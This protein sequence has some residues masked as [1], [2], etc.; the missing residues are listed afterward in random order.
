M[1]GKPIGQWQ[2]ICLCLAL[3]ILGSACSL[4]EEVIRRGEVRDAMGQGQLLLGRGDF[5]GS[6]KAFTNVLTYAN[7]EPPADAAHYHL[8]LIHAHPQNSRQDRR[9]A[10]DSFD[11]VVSQFPESSFVQPAKAWI[12][13]LNEIDAKQQEIARTKA[14]ARKSKQEIEASRAAAERAKQD[15]DRVRAEL[16]KSRQEFDRAK[17]LIEKTRQVEIDMENKRRQR[18][19]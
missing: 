13:V 16:E 17:Q 5:D 12:G 4:V 8:G 1:G 18:G 9:K 19:R 11:R 7:D 3:L 15:A 6:A 10:L 14:E 2:Q